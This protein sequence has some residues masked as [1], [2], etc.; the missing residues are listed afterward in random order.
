MHWEYN[1]HNIDSDILYCDYTIVWILLLS[2]LL[3][4]YHTSLHRQY[5]KTFFCESLGIPN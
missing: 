4:E 1:E 5:D 3:L 2:H